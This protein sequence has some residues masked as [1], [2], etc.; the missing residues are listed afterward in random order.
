M[1]W[2]AC[3]AYNLLVNIFIHVF[4]SVSLYPCLYIHVSISV[5]LYP[6]LYIHIH[7]NQPFIVFFL[8][9]FINASDIVGWSN[10]KD[11]QISKNTVN[12]TLLLGIKKKIKSLPFSPP[13]PLPLVLIELGGFKNEKKK[14][15][16]PLSFSIG[17]PAIT[18]AYLISHGKVGKKKHLKFL[19]SK[20]SFI[21]Y[22]YLLFTIYYYLLFTIY[23]LLFT[24]IYS[25]VV[26]LPDWRRR[27]V[28]LVCSLL[29]C[30]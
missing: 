27:F 4:I 23:Y 9:L 21:I 28:V 26:R 1:L 29:I 24:I 17:V 14:M 13:F 15:I 30:I 12:T 6:C 5:S 10:A 22:Y 19:I 2:N 8:F 20:P 3:V 7:I 16:F 18:L 11:R 25:T